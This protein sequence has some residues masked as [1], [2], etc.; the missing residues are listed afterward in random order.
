MESR[1]RAV[2]FRIQELVPRQTYLEQG[3]EAWSLIDSRL[4]EVLE[5]VRGLVKTPL[6]VNSWDF[7]GSF[8]YRGWRPQDCTVGAAKSRHKRGMAVDFHSTSIPAENI[9]QLIARH[10]D[11]LPYPIRLESKVNWVHLDLDNDGSRGKIIY[12]NP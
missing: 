1:T 6:I 12:F 4:I 2:H 11:R 10:R 5:W 7:G 9:R 3:E 8:Q